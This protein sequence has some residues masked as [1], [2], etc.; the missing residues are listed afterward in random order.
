MPGKRSSFTLPVEPISPPPKPA[1]AAPSVTGLGGGA[2]YRPRV[3]RAYFDAVYRHSRARRRCEYK[4]NCA[5]FKAESARVSGRARTRGA[6][7]AVGSCAKA[8]FLRKG[9]AGIA[10]HPA[11]GCSPVKAEAALAAPV[12]NRINGTLPRRAEEIARRK[13]QTHLACTAAGGAAYIGALLPATDPAP[14]GNAGRT[15]RPWRDPASRLA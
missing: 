13:G 3:R 14:R 2:G 8:W 15:P 12:E 4:H 9:L 7:G 11:P 5:I 10:R 6:P 1:V